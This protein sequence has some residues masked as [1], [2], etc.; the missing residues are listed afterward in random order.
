VAFFDA[1][2][3]K[4]YVLALHRRVS[5]FAPYVFPFTGTKP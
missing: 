5:P 3:T 1:A 2:A 4:I